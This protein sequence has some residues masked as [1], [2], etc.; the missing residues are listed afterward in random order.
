M[1]S[2]D[3]ADLLKPAFAVALEILGWMLTFVVAGLGAFGGSYLRKKGENLATREDI[4]AITHE[5]E[6][7]KAEHAEKLQKLAH[8]NQ[9]ILEQQTR[10]HQLKLAALE[11]RLEVHQEAYTHWRKLL[12]AVP[13]KDT[14]KLKV[15]VS[16]CQNWW[17]DNCLFLTAEAREAFQDAYH[18]AEKHPDYVQERRRKQ[19]KDNWAAIQRVG[20]VIVKG[21]ELPSLGERE[22]V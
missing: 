8:Q 4:G 21:V 13:A 20:E 18:R 3:I 22:T 10:K 14:E 15:V 5:V 11:K 17:K 6:G 19:V 12:L 7:I 1:N 9:E 2:A 16:E